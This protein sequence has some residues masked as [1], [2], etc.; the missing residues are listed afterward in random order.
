MKKISVIGSGSWG[1]AIAKLL[2]EK[3][4]SVTLWSWKKEESDSLAAARENKACLPGIE[5]P[6]NISYTYDLQTAADADLYIFAVPSHAVFKTAEQFKR[7]ANPAVPIVNVAKGFEK[8]GLMRLSEAIAVHLNNPVVVLSGPSHA[9]EVA[10]QIPTTIVAA[11]KDKKA[12]ELVQDTFMNDY[13][14]VYTNDDVIGV[15]VGAAL[16]NVIALC[17]GISDGLGLGDNTKAALMTR[18]LA[19]ISRLGASMGADPHTF[20]GLSGVGDLIVTC[21]SMHSRNRRAG[22]LIGQGIS[23]KEAQEK[24]QMVVEGVYATEI[25]Y[26]LSE[27]Y[28]V[29]MPI[30]HAAYEILFEEMPPRDAVL[31]LMLRDKK[32][33]KENLS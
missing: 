3:G 15:E 24:V 18:G 10:R 27:K 13:F 16:K 2:A 31:K 6:E 33:E 5:L 23:P 12:A 17:A 14:R 30:T 28:G 19:E 25:A 7:F 11:S 8:T 4:F 29:S 20:S 1:C 21:T 32:S 9:E 22:L 26:A